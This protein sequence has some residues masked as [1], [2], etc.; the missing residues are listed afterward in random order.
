MQML[1][2]SSRRKA[3]HVQQKELTDCQAETL[4]KPVF[5]DFSLTLKSIELAA[6]MILHTGEV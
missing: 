5:R 6:W 1:A 2:R 3:I 4:S